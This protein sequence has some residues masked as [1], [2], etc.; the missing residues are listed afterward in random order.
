MQCGYNLFALPLPA[1]ILIAVEGE[2]AFPPHTVAHKM[3]PNA[4]LRIRLIGPSGHKSEYHCATL[5]GNWQEE[6]MS[7]GLKDPAKEPLEG[8]TTYLASYR[9]TKNDEELLAAKPPGCFC[10]EAPVQLLFYHGDIVAP[11]QSQFTVHELSYTR[12]TR[13]GGAHPL[14]TILDKEGISQRREKTEA[15][16]RAMGFSGHRTAVGAP[17]SLGRNTEAVPLAY[18]TGCATK[19][20]NEYMQTTRRG[21]YQPAKLPP[22]GRLQAKERFL[23]TKN[24]TFDATGEYL[25]DNIDEYPAATSESWGQF[26]AYKDDPMNRTRLREEYERS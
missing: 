20:D 13:D 19:R 5:L 4:R 7:F 2:V 17:S 10:A 1:S 15:L 22:I 12:P 3:P 6:R 24:V 25:K 23:T 16:R 11:P 26:M 9:G 21:H 14:R 8:Q 18:S